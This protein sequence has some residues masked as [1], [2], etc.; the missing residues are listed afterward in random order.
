MPKDASFHASSFEIILNVIIEANPAEIIIDHSIGE[1]SI[2]SDDAFEFLTFSDRHSVHVT[3][4]VD[5]RVE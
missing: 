5:R 3:L 2:N 4:S 1:F